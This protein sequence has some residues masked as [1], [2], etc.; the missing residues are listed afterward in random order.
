MATYSKLKLSASTS[1]KGILIAATS[2]PGTTIHTAH[3]SALDEITL[4]GASQHTADVVVT[5]EFGGNSSADLMIVTVPYKA[6]WVQLVPGLIL[7]AGVVMQVYASVTN[8]IAVN[9]YVNRIT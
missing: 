9:G 6:G 1:G 4:W 2:S 5:V 8:V 7:T 3:A